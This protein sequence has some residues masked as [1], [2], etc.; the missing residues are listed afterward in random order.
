MQKAINLDYAK[1]IPYSEILFTQKN[2]EI[3]TIQSK[4]R[5]LQLLL[6]LIIFVVIVE[7]LLMLKYLKQKKILEETTGDLK[8]NND[9]LIDVN[10][11]LRQ[12]E[13]SLKISSEKLK[14]EQEIRSFFLQAI[15]HQFKNYILYIKETDI[16]ELNRYN[17]IFAS[18]F[19]NKIIIKKI[20]PVSIINNFKNKYDKTNSIKNNIANDS[21]YFYSDE[22]IF[23]IIFYNILTNA[24]KHNEEMKD[25]QVM[26]DAEIHNETIKI[27]ISDNG[28]GINKNEL[29]QLFDLR[30]NKGIGLYLSKY[31]IEKINGEISVEINN[32]GGLTFYLKFNN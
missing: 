18:L 15:T 8:N 27:I 19:Q 31:F 3:K 21:W 13:I 30:E 32:T 20:Y 16:E 4:K 6:L 24:L 10:E 25:L 1:F 22:L 14:E 11:K 12:K 2:N 17:K 29:E 23:E 28:K 9:R 26:I 7:I 5:Q